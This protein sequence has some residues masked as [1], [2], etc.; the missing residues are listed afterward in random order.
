[1]AFT[2]VLVEWRR[3]VN[4]TDGT[5]TFSPKPELR[6]A[7]PGKRTATIVVPLMD[8]VIV[9]N[10]SLADR[11]VELAGVLYNKTNSWDDMETARQNLVVGL[12][13]GPGQLHLIS[14]QRHIYYNGQITVDGVQFDAQQRSNIQDYKIKILVADALER[15]LIVTS[16]IVNS[17]AE[18]E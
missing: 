4:G 13:T 3:G 14:P 5:Y 8:G 10:L 7:T 16:K 15:N 9:Q 2:S 18:I 17:N 11:A 1:M 12:G 6:R